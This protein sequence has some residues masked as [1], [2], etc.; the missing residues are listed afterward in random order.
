MLRQ[1]LEAKTASF[2]F[3]VTNECHITA[4]TTF[5]TVRQLGLAVHFAGITKAGDLNIEKAAFF[6]NGT[7]SSYLSLSQNIA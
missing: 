6:H 1:L 3:Q 5:L 7:F 2:V 4:F